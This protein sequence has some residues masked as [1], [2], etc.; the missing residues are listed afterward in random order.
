[1]Y[2]KQLAVALLATMAAL[3]APADAEA[4]GPAFAYAVVSPIVVNGLGGRRSAVGVGGGAE[5]W[6]DRNVSAGAEVDDVYFSG[7]ERSASYESYSRPAANAFLLSGNLSRYFSRQQ[8]TSKFITGGAS[9]LT[10]GGEAIGLFNLGGGLEHRLTRR[11]ALRLE[12]RGVFVPYL[13]VLP[14]L[15]AFRAGI[16]FR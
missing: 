16:V 1:M 2:Q 8:A 11:T 15:L 7:E 10:S 5:G 12:L 9:I 14:V 6:I 3:M 4:Q 13:P